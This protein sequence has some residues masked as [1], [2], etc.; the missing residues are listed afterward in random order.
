MRTTYR[1]LAYLI[2]LEVVI[3]AMAI[4][5]GLAGLGKWVA[6]EGGTLNK[7]V[8]ES[9]SVD[10]TGVIGFAVHGINGMMVIPVLVLAFLVV[11]FFAKVPGGARLAGIVFGLVVLQVALGMGGHAVPYLALLHAANAFAILTTA[12][13]AARR[14]GRTEPVDRADARESVS[15]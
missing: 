6:D 5:F 4:A 7:Q 15:V 12:V 11:S 1:V 13:I 2:A 10:F 3:Q 8:M 9:G 14:A